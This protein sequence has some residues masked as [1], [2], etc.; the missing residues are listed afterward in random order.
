[1]G[2]VNYIPNRSNGLMAIYIL[3]FDMSN[4]SASDSFQIELYGMYIALSS[5]PK[6]DFEIESE[7]HRR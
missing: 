4:C 3:K 2:T 6:M 1:M 7:F 5:I